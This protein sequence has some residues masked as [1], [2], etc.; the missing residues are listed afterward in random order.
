MM[1]ILK[2]YGIPLNLLRA[3][4]SMYTNT[5]AK[6]MSPDGETDMF[7]I[8]AG[9]LQGDTLAPFLFIIV[10]DFALRRAIEGVVR[11]LMSDG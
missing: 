1:R 4:E 2:A 3:I 7:E 8:T 9:V 11:T 5:M 6:V 10:L